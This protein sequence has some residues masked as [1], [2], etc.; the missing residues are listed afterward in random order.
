MTLNQIMH[1][2]ID[3]GEQADLL[4]QSLHKRRDLAANHDLHRVAVVLRDFAN[5]VADS[6]KGLP[7]STRKHIACN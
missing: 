1:R 4:C 6:L 2:A 3:M 7:E 5:T